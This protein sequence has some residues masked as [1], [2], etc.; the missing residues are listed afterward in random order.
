L[1]RNPGN[2]KFEEIGMNAGL[3]L[4]R[5]YVARGA[6]AADFFNDGREGLLV[7][8]LDGQPLLLKNQTRPQGHWLRIKTVGVRSNRDG[9][10]ARVEVR[11]GGI[12]QVSEVRANS[13]FESA[14]DPRVHFGLG[15][16]NRVDSIVVRW[17]SGL[18]DHIDGQNADQELIIEEGK[19]LV[20]HVTPSEKASTGWVANPKK[21]PKF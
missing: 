12:T 5:R 2:G 7:S 19:G 4:S 8:V 16:A 11:A 6:A 15:S 20:P 17:P 3:A 14:S 18:I 21:H 13:S 9:F 1:F 10:G